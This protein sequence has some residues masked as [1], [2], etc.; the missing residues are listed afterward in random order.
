MTSFRQVVLLHLILKWIMNTFATVLTFYLGSCSYF[1]FTELSDV[2]PILL[3]NKNNVD[4]IVKIRL[5]IVL[6]GKAGNTI[7]LDRA[8][9]TINSLHLC[10]GIYSKGFI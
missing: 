1:H 10:L 6:K 2:I 9:N 4:L 5:Q 3:F 7:V 8:L